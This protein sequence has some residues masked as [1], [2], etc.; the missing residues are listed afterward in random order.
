MVIFRCIVLVSLG[1]ESP[2][3]ARESRS[4]DSVGVN[5]SFSC[6][7]ILTVLKL[8]PSFCTIDGSTVMIGGLFEYGAL[9]V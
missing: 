2:A 1:Y 6:I 8:P 4:R 5:P 7:N 3:L 9:M